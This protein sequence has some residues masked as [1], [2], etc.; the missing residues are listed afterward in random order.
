[1]GGYLA[2][3][4]VHSSVISLLTRYRLKSKGF[5]IECHWLGYL[6]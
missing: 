1:M 4:L 5:P 3:Q 6:S 2:N